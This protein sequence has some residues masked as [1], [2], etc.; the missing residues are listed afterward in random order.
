MLDLQYHYGKRCMWNDTACESVLVSR[1]H[2]SHG[3]DTEF[4]I[5]DSCYR[6]PRHTQLVLRYMLQAPGS[7][8]GSIP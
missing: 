7:P 1:R 3:V 4:A 8:S 2:W 6:A 5:A